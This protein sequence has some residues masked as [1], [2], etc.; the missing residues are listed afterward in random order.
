MFGCLIN[1]DTV[2]LLTDRFQCTW[3]SEVRFK[4]SGIL[5]L[6]LEE[7]ENLKSS[8]HFMEMIYPLNPRKVTSDDFWVIEIMKRH[9]SQYLIV[10]LA[11]MS[12]SAILDFGCSLDTLSGQEAIRFQRHIFTDK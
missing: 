5:Q 6:L 4:K 11:S 1:Y 8:W 10:N 7:K 2:L 9:S 3:G 12:S